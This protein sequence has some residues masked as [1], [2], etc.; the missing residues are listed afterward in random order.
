MLSHFLFNSKY[1]LIPSNFL[2]EA[3]LRTFKQLVNSF[4]FHIW[5]QLDP[6][7]I[8]ISTKLW[9]IKTNLCR[10]IIFHNQNQNQIESTYCL[11]SEWSRWAP[12]TSISN[13]KRLELYLVIYYTEQTGKFPTNKTII[14]LYRYRNTW[15]DKNDYHDLKLRNWHC[16]GEKNWNCWEQQT[17]G[18]KM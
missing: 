8:A 12:I 18:C 10:N 2:E 1:L 11:Y 17:V 13:S 9:R 16:V 7:K 4:N 3:F 14:M 15:W 5:K 6:V